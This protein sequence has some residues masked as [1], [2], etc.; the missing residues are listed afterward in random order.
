[1]SGALF[2]S[3]AL[4]IAVA[5]G[6]EFARRIRR[7]A[8]PAR[9]TGFDIAFATALALGVAALLRGV[10]F[11]GGAAALLACAIAGT[12]LLLRLQSAQS[13][14][15]PRVAVGAPILDF[16]APDEHGRPFRLSS[17]VG[18]PILLKLFRGHW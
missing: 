12:M 9:R 7:V 4:A 5:A 2:A 14:N 3:L 16:A 13:R 8:V 1:V 6:A 11:A 17:L 15:R 10:G 18:R